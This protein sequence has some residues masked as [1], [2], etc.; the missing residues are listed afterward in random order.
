MEMLNYGA[1][2]GVNNFST[3]SVPIDMQMS[4]TSFSS[5]SP[6][7]AVAAVT[8]TTEQSACHQQFHSNAN[9]TASNEK[10]P[11]TINHHHISTPESNHDS[12]RSI[13]DPKTFCSSNDQ[14]QPQSQRQSTFLEHKGSENVKRFSVNNLLQLANNCRSDDHRL[15]GS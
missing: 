10:S 1:I 8:A 2:D 6:S 14:Q 15:T 12:L 4:G 5:S 13:Q 9:F 3:T 7:I 11:W